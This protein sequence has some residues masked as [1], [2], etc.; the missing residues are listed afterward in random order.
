MESAIKQ[1]QDAKEFCDAILSRPMASENVEA[2]YLQLV[3][4]LGMVNNTV[5]D[6]LRMLTE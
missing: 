3:V 5:S 2:E 1:L 6:V 4:A